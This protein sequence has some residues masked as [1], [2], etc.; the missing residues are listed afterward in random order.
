MSLLTVH[1]PIEFSGTGLLL[2]PAD[3]A[4]VVWTDAWRLLAPAVA[5]SSGRYT[6]H[7]IMLALMRGTNQLWTWWN[8]GEM[9]AAVVTE[10]NDYPNK[11][12]VC[13]MLFCSGRNMNLWCLPL[14]AAIE[15][16]AAEQGTK[17]MC[18]AGR[19]GWERVLKDYRKTAVIL[20]KRLDG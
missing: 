16:W 9:V 2:I 4:L 20:E 7:S 6:Q 11:L 12:R 13:D 17:L 14:L 1:L 18:V 3:G 15:T 10:L 5:L 8:D 19:I